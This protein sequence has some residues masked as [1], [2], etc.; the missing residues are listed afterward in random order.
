M[1]DSAVREILFSYQKKRDKAEYEFEERKKR[2]YNKFP[3]IEKI[4]DEITNVGLKMMRLVLSTSPD[5]E[6]LLAKCREDI[7][8]LKEE[9][10]NL[11]FFRAG[12]KPIKST[13]VLTDRSDGIK[14][15][16]GIERKNIP[17]FQVNRIYSASTAS[18]CPIALILFNKEGCE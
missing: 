14:P 6:N 10:Q 3:E 1:K 15:G 11:L 16:I 8:S 9:K 18:I 2:I 4:D 12:E 17:I 7:N 13:K 5:K